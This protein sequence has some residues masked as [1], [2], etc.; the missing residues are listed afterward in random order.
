[1]MDIKPKLL[2]WLLSATL[3]AS[4]GRP[5]AKFT[6]SGKTKAANPI[7]FSNES[8]KAE[9]Y[10]WD[11]G[12]GNTSTEASPSHRYMSS[13]NYMVRMKAIDSK[14]KVQEKKIRIIV[15]APELCL[16]EMKTPYGSVLIQLYDST[17][18]H[19]DNFIKL[20]EQEFYDSLLFH[21]VI[22]GFMVQG[23]DP[24]SKNARQGM[25]LGMGGP[26]YTI[27]AEFVDSLVHVRGA[28]AAASRPG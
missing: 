1:M 20:A 13:G 19:Q 14:E 2:F 8:E 18:K 17:P 15:D 23:G 28:V 9:R 10:E 16:V 24:Q 12:D 6:Y 22:Q 27:P 11:F 25:P 5:V 7:Q 26:G 3:L 21:R 4:C